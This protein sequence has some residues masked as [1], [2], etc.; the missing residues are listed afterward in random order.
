[1]GYTE[2]GSA[3][4]VV[5]VEEILEERSCSAV[6]PL[7]IMRS[8]VSDANLSKMLRDIQRRKHFRRVIFNEAFR[9]KTSD[10]LASNRRTPFDASEL[11]FFVP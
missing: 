9:F 3:P 8:F 4:L 6:T 10:W 11:L 5:K 2:V 7:K 1:M